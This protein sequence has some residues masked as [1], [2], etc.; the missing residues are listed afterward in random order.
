MQATERTES[1][2]AHVAIGFLLLSIVAVIPVATVSLPP[3][4]DYPNH[5]ARMYLLAVLPDAPDLAHWYSTNWRPLPDLAFD[6]IVPLLV[7]LMPVEI[8]MRLVLAAT[9]L[10]LAGGCTVLHRV[11]HGRWSLWPLFAFLLLYN[12]MLLWG[13]LNYLAGLALMLWGLA[14]WVAIER[15]P[16]WLRVAVG[17]VAATVIYLAHLAAFGCYALAVLAFALTGGAPRLSRIATTLATFVPALILFAAGPTAGAAEHWSYGN[18]LR[19]LDLPVSIFDNY[20][21]LF[22][23]ATFGVLLIAVLVGLFR[24]GI[25]LH[26]R[27]RWS[28]VAI[29]VA[30][31]IIPSRLLSASGIDHRLPIAAALLFV[32]ISDWGAVAVKWRKVI[33]VALFALLAV[34]MGVV[35]EAWLNADRQYDALRPAIAAIDRGATVAIAAPAKDVQAGGV[36]LLYFPTLAVI[37]RHAFVDT[38][39]ADPRQ[40]PLTLTDAA[41]AREC[42]YHRDA[43][44][45]AAVDGTLPAMTGFDN[46]AIVD[47]PAGFDPGKLSGTVLFSAPRLVLLSLR[48]QATGAA[49]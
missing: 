14:L 20:D 49:Q 34:R 2:P 5:M 19:K 9:L 21:R 23:G 15:R 47:P 27:L 31:V 17:A 18:I 46:L 4:L 36:P 16:V 48:S 39:F 22:D 3:I 29:L 33:T 38:L 43:L 44:W 6:A 11:A 37:E 24:G 30:F 35:E 45:R 1:R 7:H 40:Q 12:R 32:A 8:A 25:T 42:Q 26:G 28:L 10:A 13:F 41:S